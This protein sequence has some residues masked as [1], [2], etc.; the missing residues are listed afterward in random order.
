MADFN[1]TDMGGNQRDF[2]A[3]EW[4]QL[5]G[6]KRLSEED[7][8]VVIDRLLA[9]YWKP[10]YCFIRQ[11]GRDNET[12]KDLTQGFFF[13]VVMRRDLFSQADKDQGRFR[14]FL[15][16]ALNC[17]LTDHWRKAH[18][19][20]RSPSQP[21]QAMTDEVACAIPS[22]LAR[23][24]PDIV[25]Q[26]QWGIELLQQAIQVTKQQYLDGARQAHWQVFQERTL[27]PT[28]A[29]QSPP[30]Y[31]QICEHLDQVT[32]QQAQSMEFRV[33]QRFGKNL[34]EILQRQMADGAEVETEIDELLDI[35]SKM[36]T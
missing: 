23:S 22:Q 14:T 18:A 33:R 21:L 5:Q 28:L 27:G 25:F 2:P 29:G 31:R 36:G 35:F 20:K 13:D 16:A 15:L 4:T 17:Y 34:R 7:R 32:E 26:Y 30:S 10:V 9:R 3:T 11:K 8:R 24:S 12:A 1:S 19:Q 6:I